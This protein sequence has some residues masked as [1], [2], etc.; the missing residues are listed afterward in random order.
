MKPKPNLSFAIM[1]H[2]IDPAFIA[3]F[4][5]VGA[6]LCFAPIEPAR[7]LVWNAVLSGVAAALAMNVL[8]LMSRRPKVMGGFSPPV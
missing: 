7:M 5:A 4:M 8:Q 1:D 6:A 3:A 2:H